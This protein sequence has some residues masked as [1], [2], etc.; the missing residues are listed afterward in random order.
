MPIATVPSVAPGTSSVVYFPLLK[1]NPCMTSLESTYHPTIDPLS[2][3][4]LAD[5]CSAPLGPGI[6]IYLPSLYRNPAGMPLGVLYT[7]TT[8]IAPLGLRP[9]ALVL[10]CRPFG[11]SSLV[12]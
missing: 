5:D 11:T 6:S 7:P 2:F 8:E 3:I 9:F 1:R 4:E 10:F 12:N